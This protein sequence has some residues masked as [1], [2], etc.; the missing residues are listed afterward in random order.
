MKVFLITAVWGPWHTDAFARAT[1]PTLLAEGNLPAIT[2]LHDC[3]YRIYTTATSAKRLEEL[4]AMACL[5]QLMPVE[6]IYLSS[7]DTISSDM[8]VAAWRAAAEDAAAVK[9]AVVA[10]H[11]DTPWTNGSFSFLGR[12]LAEGFVAVVV[13]NIRV[14]S[15]TFI[16]ALERLRQGDI[17]P[18]SLSSGLAT[19]LSLR[20]FHP[21]SAAMVPQIGYSASATEIYW[22][23]PGLGLALRHASR[24]AIAA[25][26]HLCPLDFEFYMHGFTNSELVL[27]VTNAEDMLMLSMAP[28]F[29]DFGLLEIGHAATPN[30]VGLWCAHPQNDTPLNPWYATKEMRLPL[31]GL[32]Q[33]ENWE[34][35]KNA[36]DDF[37]QR[38][39]GSS[40]ATKLVMALRNQ[41]CETAAQLIAF[42]LQE[43]DFSLQLHSLHPNAPLVM[44]APSEI[45]FEQFGRLNIYRLLRPNNEKLLLAFVMSHF[46]I[47]TAATTEQMLHASGINIRETVTTNRYTILVID[48]IIEEFSFIPV[49]GGAIVGH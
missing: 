32:T 28:L 17:I 24:P 14:V 36:A 7:A 39:I 38:V 35:A 13:P 48:R 23:V 18:I 5:R 15:E 45:A 41:G 37:M 4:P 34:K 29:K 46:R 30:L 21:L 43:T 19:S 40:D 26:P 47:G 16:P 42:A 49:R 11:P 2:Q 8:H 27:N 12:A 22:A 44:L 20:H 1:L 9:A 10:I 6:L 3:R 33:D 25:V 31:G